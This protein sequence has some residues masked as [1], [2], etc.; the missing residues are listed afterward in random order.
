MRDEPTEP[1]RQLLPSMEK[2][3][4]NGFLL[5]LQES[6]RRVHAGAPSGDSQAR[7]KRTELRKKASKGGLSSFPVACRSKLASS[8]G[9]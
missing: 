9:P 5:G 7:R 8:G 1:K 6:L 3:V 2:V 4:E